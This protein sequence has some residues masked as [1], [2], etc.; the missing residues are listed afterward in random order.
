MPTKFRLFRFL[1]S[2]VAH[3]MKPSKARFAA[4]AKNGSVIREPLSLP[5]LVSNPNYNALLKSI[6]TNQIEH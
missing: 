5:S 2:L 1:M 3:Q 4:R 6:R